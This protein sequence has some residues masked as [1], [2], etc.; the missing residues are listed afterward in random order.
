MSI[1]SKRSDHELVIMVA[2]REQAAH[3]LVILAAPPTP[4]TSEFQ[5]SLLLLPIGVSAP[6][7][8]MTT[9]FIV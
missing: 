2:V 1:M 9:L 7:P 3:E 5:K 4:L 8:V 6:I